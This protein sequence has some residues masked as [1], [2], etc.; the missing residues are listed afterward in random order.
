MQNRCDARVLAKN[1]LK[2]RNFNTGVVCFVWEFG[3]EGEGFGKKEGASG[4][5]RRHREERALKVPLKVSILAWRLMRD[6][7]PTKL[8]LAN[9]GILSVEERL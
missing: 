1:Q 4:R 8:N 3:R 7:L 2:S 5:N 6:R 9:R